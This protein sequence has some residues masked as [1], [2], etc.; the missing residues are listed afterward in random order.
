MSP[1]S[2]RM[3][4]PVH[5]LLCGHSK[6][7]VAVLLSFREFAICDECVRLCMILVNVRTQDAEWERLRHF[8][9]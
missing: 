5:C 6:W 4:A 1:G 3:T 9:P 2:T 8:A 7:E